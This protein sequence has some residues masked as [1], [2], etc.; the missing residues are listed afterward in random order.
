MYNLI[1]GAMVSDNYTLMLS[2]LPLVSLVL[3]IQGKSHIDAF[4]ITNELHLELSFW[5]PTAVG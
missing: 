2:R 4:S 5:A 1:L 3:R